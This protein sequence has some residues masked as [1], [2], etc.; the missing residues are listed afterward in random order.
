M[1]GR[2]SIDNLSDSL[3]EMISNNGM[4]EE[5][6]I[7]LLE[8]E[9]VIN[10][11]KTDSKSIV[12]AINELFQSA[13]NGK[14]LIANAIGEP[15]SSEDNFSAMSD[16]ISTIVDTLK[17]NITAKG[18]TI[19]DEKL[20]ELVNKVSEIGGST[21][22][23]VLNIMV[24]LSQSLGEPTTANDTAQ[25][26]CEKIDMITQSFRDKL[27][28]KVV[29]ILGSEKINELVEKVDFVALC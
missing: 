29:D 10:S 21:D 1:S 24:A 5:Q 23:I 17:S 12:G 9:E 25:E 19:S 15:L 18:I 2:I 6:I 22:E 11:L 26:M 3:K 13:N 4:T 16:K 8:N 27:A 28:E 7:E 14:E 20:L